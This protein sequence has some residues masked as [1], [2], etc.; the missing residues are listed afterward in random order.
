[1]TPLGAADASR[2]VPIVVLETDEPVHRPQRRRLGHDTA[3]AAR[4][5]RADRRARGRDARLQRRRLRDCARLRL[6]PTGRQ[7]LEI[8]TIPG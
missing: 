2:A 6:K 1:V 5:R 7:V 8:N 3:G 4:D